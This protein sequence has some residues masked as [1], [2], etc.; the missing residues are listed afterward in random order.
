MSFGAP[1]F[2]LGL[3]LLALPWWLHRLRVQ[4]ADRQ[5]FASLRFMQPAMERV[6]TERRIRYWL[7][8][9][10][11]WALVAAV[12]LAFAQPRLPGAAGASTTSAEVPVYVLVDRS[13]SMQ[14]VLDGER[15]Q[16]VADELLAGTPAGSAP[17]LL[18]AGQQL[19]TLLA[20][21][22]SRGEWTAALQRL[23]SDNSRLSFERLVRDL[24]ARFRDQRGRPVAARIH[25]LS[26]FQASALPDQFSRLA[27]PANLDLR[28]HPVEDLEDSNWLVS[29]ITADTEEPGALVVSLRHAG[30][31]DDL[32]GIT[33]SAR[34]NQ[35]QIVNGIDPRI[36]GPAAT[37]RLPATLLPGENRVEVRIDGDA[38]EADNQYYAVISVGGSIAVPLLT[39]D[40][41]G[42]ASR[43]LSTALEA[44][45]G[46]QRFKAEPLGSF[47]PRTLPRHRWLAVTDL[48][49]VG[50]ELEPALVRWIAD[51]GRL[52]AALGESAQRLE[53]VP[54]TGHRLEWR[55]ALEQAPGLAVAGLNRGH[56]LLGSAPGWQDIAVRR[57][58]PVI[59]GTED[60]LLVQLDSG[61]PLVLAHRLG[62]GQVLLLTSDLNREWNDLP[63]RP[64]FVPWLASV[65]QV[66]SGRATL[67]RQ[68]YV[69][70][71]LQSGPASRQLVAPDG[72]ELFGLDARSPVVLTTAGFYEQYD[73]QSA[74]TTFAVNVDPRESDLR[75]MSQQQLEAWRQVVVRPEAQAAATSDRYERPTAT[76]LPWLMALLLLL[77]IEM[78]LANRHLFARPEPRSA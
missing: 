24:E 23:T 62:E 18:A 19:E 34:L 71:A 60:E 76:A 67:V 35:Q 1:W 72:G 17:G 47:D 54:V 26:D 27:P 12:V 57:V 63:A 50:P 65:A 20:P 15:L 49:A 32:A 14:R 41:R 51:G 11:R 43:F 52:F 7:L 4:S 9:A 40:P 28:L 77:L 46:E 61:Q 10:L 33:L 74:M 39:Q 13:A 69:G 38:F 31:G 68:R 30:T 36:D 22:A 8:L 37:I 3:G 55:V 78:L 56:P 64:V 59:T 21:G 42:L 45:G 66:L 2:L 70:E 53:R 73:E 75:A 58:A 25:L 6:F 48:G 29:G 44:V 16:A 5:P